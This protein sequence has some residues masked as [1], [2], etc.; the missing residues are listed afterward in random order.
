MTSGSCSG[1]VG[2]P[3]STSPSAWPS[4]AGP[5]SRAPERCSGTA[6]DARAGDHPGRRRGSRPDPGRRGRPA[7]SASGL[8]CS[9]RCSERCERARR[10]LR[11]GQ[12]VYGVNTGMGALSSV[13]LTEQQQL[14]HQRNLLLARATGGPPWLSP[15]DVRAIITVRLLTFLSGDA[16]VSGGLCQRLADFLN[17]GIVPAVPQAGRGLRGR[18]HAAGARVR[19]GGWHRPGARA[20]RDPAA[21]ARGA[22]PP[23]ADRV[24]P[25]PEGG[26]RP[27]PGGARGHRPGRACDSAR[28]PR[29]RR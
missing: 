21:C 26:H 24:Q 2:L 9:R 5:S 29:W 23:R 19:A 10:A 3:S 20:G 8:T 1:T 25:R 7:P 16:A 11:D 15:P 4:C 28:P 14:S 6:S 18:D 12:P 22:A 13:R 27:D 17:H